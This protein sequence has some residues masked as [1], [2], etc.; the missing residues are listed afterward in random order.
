MCGNC[1]GGDTGIDPVTDPDNCTMT[2]TIS[3]I[4]VRDIF[5]VLPNPAH[6]YLEIIT[7]YSSEYDVKLIDML[8]VV[9]HAETSSGSHS[10][11]ISSYPPGPYVI[12]ISIDGSYVIEKL[13]VK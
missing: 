12:A 1:S 4:D 7:D 3:S 5:T 6:D 2:S 9:H 11:D 13:I 8:G 10:L